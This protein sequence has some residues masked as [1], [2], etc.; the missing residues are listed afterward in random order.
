MEIS[1]KQMLVPVLSAV[2]ATVPAWAAHAAISLT[3][4]AGD[5]Q[6][7]LSWSDAGTGSV[8]QVYYD[9]D[10]NPAGRVRL[11][12]LSSSEHAYT[13]SGLQNGTPYWFWI[14]YKDS[15][16]KLVNSNSFSA[17]PVSASS[18]SEDT[19]DTSSDSYAASLSSEWQGGNEQGN[20]YSCVSG[21]WQTP[22]TTGDTGQPLRIESEHFS[23]YWA[24]G[25][26]ITTSKAQTALNT[27]ETIW[28]AYFG[29]IKFKEPYCE[30]SQKYKATVHFG[31]SFGLTGGGWYKDGH[32][33][34]GMWVGP[35]TA[36]DK[37]GLAHEFAHGAQYMVTAFPGCSGVGCW[38]HESHANWMAHQMFPENV[39]CS[40]MQVNM[41]HL[42]YGNSRTR[43][44]NWQFME[45]LKDKFGIGVV[46]KMWSSPTTNKDEWQKLMQNQGWDISKLND[47]FGDWAMHNVTW[48]YLDINGT[49]R[50]AFFR[51]AYGAVDQAPG[52]NTQRRLRL[53]QLETLNSDWKTNHRFVSPYY[54]APQRWGYN[55]IRLY[56][57]SGASKVTVK[58]RGVVQ[59]NANSDW[60]W[61][62]VAT[63]SHLDS[64]RYSTIQR[65]SDN[66]ASVSINSGDEVYLVVMATPSEYQKILWARHVSDGTPYPSIYRYP[67]M[68]ELQGAWPDG[69]KNGSKDSCPSGT[70][71]H[72]NGGGCATTSTPSSVYVGPYAKV[73]GGTVTGN[74]RIEDHATIIHGNVSGNSTVGG[75]TLL[76]SASNMPYSWYHTF[77]VQDNATVK[78]T[79]Y[80]MG[81]FGDKT[82]GGSATLLGDLEYYSDKYSNFFYG[83]VNDSW[84]GDSSIND[85]TVQ[86]PYSWR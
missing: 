58:F 74:S 4:N 56:P 45:Y 30:S 28:T 10:S 23:A 54:W 81:W 70:V 55:I 44:C 84:S 69:F 26:N 79:F 25:T 57:E 50:G 18:G 68:V 21:T 85:V 82:A 83:L 6:V 2:I 51:Q 35:A 64:P 65:G 13:A 41:P 72:S 1:R 62:L 46:G 3:G 29:R 17:T 34:M 48:D 47:E 16:G 12:S 59:Q 76:G 22:S 36:S 49:N 24:D 19:S 67:Y 61:G 78:S 14:K 11:S 40:E 31:N 80:P 5:S 15:S 37:W 73:L 63:D 42:H 75:L 77:N 8:Y 60:R 39:H 9:T 7:S 33:L 27:L 43:Y 38:I 32:R 52:A 20:T 66:Q 53:T 86:P 71:R